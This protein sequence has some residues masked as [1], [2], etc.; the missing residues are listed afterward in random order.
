ML[1]VGG[2]GPLPCLSA[3]GTDSRGT[4][5]I[6]GGGFS[7]NRRQGFLDQ[8]H[9]VSAAGLARGLAFQGFSRDVDKA[10]CRWVQSPA[11]NVALVGGFQKAIY[12]GISVGVRGIC[13]PVFGFQSCQC[14]LNKLLHTEVCCFADSLAFQSFEG[15]ANQASQMRSGSIVV[16]QT[17]HRVEELIHTGTPVRVLLHILLDRLCKLGPCLL[18]STPCFPTIDLRFQT[19]HADLKIDDGLVFVSLSSTE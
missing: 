17:E 16:V 19:F 13:Q 11:D 3:W 8:G 2:I 6:T 1:V 5:F 4:S 14:R 7:L 10:G 15:Q 9:D 18:V 12:T